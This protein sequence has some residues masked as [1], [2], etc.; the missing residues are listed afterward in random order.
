MLFLCFSLS[1]FSLFFNQRR[2]QPLTISSTAPPLP[3]GRAPSRG[4]GGGGA[5]LLG[6]SGGRDPRG[7]VRGSRAAKGRT[8]HPPSQGPRS[9]PVCRTVSPFLISPPPGSG[10]VSRRRRWGRRG[11]GHADDAPSAES[12]F[13]PCMQP[14]CFFPCCAVPL[15]LLARAAAVA[16]RAAS[17]HRRCLFMAGRWGRDAR[18]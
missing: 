15:A 3:A 10:P 18:D 8:G 16:P 12:C 2:R 5:P 17:N 9:Q 1:F 14:L 7:W 13:F 11:I 4:R 6:S